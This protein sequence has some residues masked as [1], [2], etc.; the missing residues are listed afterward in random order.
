M[1]AGMLALVEGRGASLDSLGR[2]QAAEDGSG[3]T[4]TKGL[5]KVSLRTVDSRIEIE[6]R[7]LI[8]SFS[9]ADLQ[10]ESGRGVGR[11]EGWVGGGAC[12]P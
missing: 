11:R 4:N 8:P 12:S 10:A 9:D 7:E 1:Y 2:I 3:G 6:T 5:R